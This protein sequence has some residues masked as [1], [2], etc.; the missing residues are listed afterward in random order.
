LLKPK[1]GG[2][3]KAE[4]VKK[5]PKAVKN[6]VRK[7]QLVLGVD[8]S[9]EEAEDLSLVAVVGRARGKR[10][11]PSYLRRWAA[12]HWEGL[13]KQPP[14]IRVLTKGWF[15]FTLQNKWEVEVVTSHPWVMSGVSVLLNSWTPFFDSKTKK[16][17]KELMWVRPSG[18]PINLWNETHFAAIG[19][20]LGEY[21]CS[22]RTFQESS[23]YTVAKIMV[24]IDLK[25]GL[26]S[27]ISVKTKDGD[28]TQVL[29]YD[30]VPFR[31]HRCHAYGHLVASCPFPYRG[32]VK[33][34]DE[35]SDDEKGKG[36]EEVRTADGGVEG[37]I[38]P[39]QEVFSGL[40]MQ[41]D[42][43]KAFLGCSKALGPIVDG[44]QTPKGQGLGSDGPT[45]R[46]VP[47]SR[48]DS[49]SLHQKF[50]IHRAVGGGEISGTPPLVIFASPSPVVSCVLPPSESFFTPS[51]VST[52]PSSSSE[53]RSIRYA[54]RSRE[55]SVEYPGGKGLSEVAK[56]V[57]GR[58]R[59]RKSH[60]S[61]AQ[62]RAKVDVDLGKQSSI[63][64]ALRAEKAQGGSV[65]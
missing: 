7:D 5:P 62:E 24:K 53:S 17:D 52:N 23:F 51:I 12:K 43:G 14:G 38:A 33:R 40:N 48:A 54:L 63:E 1:T 26:S 49:S 19:N 55:I 10:F 2:K 15:A 42:C 56:N 8:V 46:M 50:D 6:R 13:V 58:G 18:F 37:G 47:T 45:I 30:G 35:V 22:D 16:V 61:K 3:G 32:G 29:D 57:G 65:K 41:A 39:A 60:L 34:I 36:E 31:C 25:L 21:V 4:A 27:E 64:W 28:F 44:L 59:G 20:F 11:G 9:L